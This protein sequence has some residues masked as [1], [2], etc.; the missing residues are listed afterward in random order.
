MFLRDYLR[1]LLPL[2]FAFTAY[3]VLAVPFLEPA[4][5]TK[6][7]RHWKSPAIP[8]R[9][10]WW[11]AFFLPGDW[12]RNTP[13]IVTTDDAI[14]LFQTR[15]QISKTR[16]QFKPLTILIPQREGATKKA[17]LI[18]NPSGAEIEFKTEVE[19]S[20]E[21]PPVESGQ[22]LGEISIY[23]PPD[24]VSK[25]DGMLIETRD[26]RINKRRIWT[27]QSIT[28]QLGNSRIDGQN[29]NIYLDKD[30]LSSDQPNANKESPFNGLNYLELFYVDRVHIGLNPGGLWPSKDIPDSLL[31]PAYAT[32]KCKGTFEFQFHQSEAIL[33]RDVHME[34][35]VQGLPIDTFDC[36]ELRLQIGWD[37]K[38]NTAPPTATPPSTKSI[39]SSNWKVER[40]V[41][42][43]ASGRDLNDHSRWLKLLAPGMKAEAQGQHLVIDI[44]NG[45][46]TLNNKLPGTATRDSSRVYLKYDSIQVSCPEVQ[47]INAEAIANTNEGAAAL[48]ASSKSNRLGVVIA[49]GA[50]WGQMD[51]KGESWKLSWGKSLYIRPQGDKDQMIIEGSANV[52]NPSQGRFTAEQLHLWLTPMNKELASQ[53]VAQYPDGKVPQALPDRMEAKGD[54]VVDSPQLR[55]RVESMQVWFAYPTT[56][57][58]PDSKVNSAQ[59]TGSLPQN[60]AQNASANNLATAAP[61]NLAPSKG[62]PPSPLLQPIYADSS[63]APKNRL[64]AVPASPLNVTAK[65]MRARVVN[66]GDRTFVDDLNLEGNFILTKD[67]VSDSSPW[68]FTATG[69]RLLL[70]QKTENATDIHITGVADHDAEIKIGSGRVVAQE[71]RLMQSENQFWIDHPG[72]LVIPVEALRNTSLQSP[73]SL[74][75]LPNARGSVNPTRSIA[76]ST[77]NDIRWREPPRLRW[78]KRMTFDGKSARFG[79]GVTIDC[80]IESDEAT[81]WHISATADQMVVDMDQPVSLRGT[82]APTPSAQAQVS[83]IRLDGNVDIRAVQTDYQL[84]RRS[85]EHMKLPQLDFDVPSQTWVGHGPGELWSRRLGNANP[86]S[87]TFPTAP[88]Q[89]RFPSSAIDSDLQCIHLSFIGRMQ[90]ALAQR[91]ASFF[92]RIEALIGPIVDWD[93]EVNVHKLDRLGKNQS[94]LISDQ[95]NIFDA[96]GLSWNQ[97]QNA[98]RVKPPTSS[99]EIE[100]Q[101]RVVMSSNTD[102][103]QITIEADRLRYSAANNMVGV[104]RS[105]R[106]SAVISR[107]QA[108][109][110]TPEKLAVS[111]AA[112]NL[113]TGEFDMTISKFEGNLPF[114]MQ[115][116]GQAMP[117]RPTV[118]APPQ[119]PN[120]NSNLL[121]SPRDNPLQPRRP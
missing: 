96:S 113:K 54:V 25:R 12:Q 70:S 95:L 8:T 80:K 34:H 26:V 79:G 107:V 58:R 6:T 93:D 115:P 5:V 63:I 60:N 121:R 24:E 71:L 37:P 56:A 94:H 74:V 55:A 13:K 38:R 7:V 32:L 90:G 4:K 42:F 36:D 83:V 98:S 41:A 85:L 66:S 106:Q 35:L 15:T 46:I 52:S 61:L 86:L 33:R 39:S 73:S 103:G 67:Q 102:N 17:I 28:M 65:T 21:L 108:N 9:V 110:A 18:N 10:D 99:W 112:M 81:L 44:L 114:N 29:L 111:H 43:G 50:G 53:L 20:K 62:L 109:G 117:Q 23:S 91:N 76:K 92:D 88:A 72:E 30:L 69:D 49:S 48:G 1:T 100:A 14:L 78:G 119:Q 84:R 120:S 40:I 19:W 118:A 105:P 104:E 101:S 87:G 31:R 57:K 97:N 45:S 16:W 3:Q 68:P 64:P 75:S 2:V 82:S 11:E 47:Y 22:L 77:G 89:N 27:D 59:A 116:P 51:S